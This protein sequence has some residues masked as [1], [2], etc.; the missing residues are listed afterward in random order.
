[1]FLIEGHLIIHQ[2]T[3]PILIETCNNNKISSDY[4]T[5]SQFLKTEFLSRIT[6]LSFRSGKQFL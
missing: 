2:Q 3:K 6:S 5:L 4:F 1:M